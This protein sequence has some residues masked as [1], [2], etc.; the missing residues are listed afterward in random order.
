M[1]AAVHHKPELHPDVIAER[2]ARRTWVGIILFLMLSGIGMWV[3]AAILAISDPTISIVPDYHEKA[4]HWDEHVAIQQASNRL[5]WTVHPHVIEGKLN[6]TVGEKRTLEVF[7][8]S[9]DAQPLLG[10]TGSVRVYHHARG[11]DVQTADLVESEPGSYSAQLLMDK[12]GIWQI[13]LKLDRKDEHFEW[14][15]EHVLR[16]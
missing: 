8:R 4:L 7:I 16:D 6:H 5:G 12:P 14:T 2:K 15:S 13:E 9:Q 11:R 3:Y 1:I 10:A